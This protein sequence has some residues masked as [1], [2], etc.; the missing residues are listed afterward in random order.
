[1]QIV[2]KPL[3]WI[4]P[5]GRLSPAAEAGVVVVGTV[6]VVVEFVKVEPVTVA[7]S[8]VVE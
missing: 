3:T 2:F 1:M 4:R 8:E 6:D 7:G 5:V